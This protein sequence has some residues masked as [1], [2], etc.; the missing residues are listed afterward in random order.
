MHVPGVRPVNRLILVSNR[1]PVTAHVVD[2]EVT[3]ERS[4]GG[5]ASGLAGPHERSGGIW[6]GWPGDL[7]RM[8]FAQRQTLEESLK[9]QRIQP[10]YLNRADVKGFYDEVS[11][12]VL[13]PVLH[14]R[15]DQLPL[16]PVGWAEYRRVS[17]VFAQAAVA[18]YEPGDVI[19]VHDYHLF[20]VPGLIRE[21]LPE[22]KIGFFLHVPFPSPDV[23]AVVPWRREILESVLAADL[24]GFHVSDYVKHFREACED[25]LG[26]ETTEKGV[27]FRGREARVDAFPL[28]IDVKFWRDL[29]RRPD[30]IARVAEIRSQ[31]PGRMIL[32][33][34]DRLD[35]TKGILRRMVALELL[36]RADPS[37]AER[38]RLIQV[39]VPSRE[40]I[41]PYSALKRRI[42]EIVGRIN[43]NY[44][45]T[46]DAPIRMLSRN[47]APEDVTALYQAA[48]VML[49]TPLRDGMNLVAKEFVAARE[50]EDGVLILSEFA[51]AV[52]ELEGAIVVNPYDVEEMGAAIKRAL[53]MPLAEQKQRMRRLRQRVMQVDVGKWAEGFIA[54]LGATPDARRPERAEPTLPLS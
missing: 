24:I 3:L 13:W 49:V 34:I 42:D 45:T 25:L 20:L 9:K 10:V 39:V 40:A 22:A 30:V 14:Y 21:A 12:G 43:G 47:L 23:F 35:Y 27:I 18:A 36:F 4:S 17:E 32:T 26:L 44:G 2:G 7:P 54:T 31:A 29:A 41:E 19:W 11:N 16:H 8:S 5:L 15:L 37:L 6:I 28:G 53:E 51:G 46:A 52:D 33:G 1:L 38:L 50:K 48:D